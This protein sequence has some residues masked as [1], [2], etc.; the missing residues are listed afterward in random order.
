M[1]EETLFHLAREKPPGERAAFL[2]QACA[3]DAALRRRLEVLL[4]AH[5]D[6]ESLLDR[7]ALERAAEG[8][9]AL[10]QQDLPALGPEPAAEAETLPPGEQPSGILAPG[11][12]VRYFGDYELLEEIA[13]GGMGV[14][15]KARQVSLN[16]VVALKMIL[17]GQLAA[18]ADVQ[19][20]QREAEAAANLDHPHIV[21]IYEVGEHEGQ[22][23]FSMKLI[24]GSSLAQDLARFSK[25]PKAAAQLLAA[26][27]RAVHH[28]HQRGILHRDLK[29]GN[30]L[31]DAAGQPHIT[32]FGLAKR[33]SGEGG[34]TQS[35]AIVGTPSYMAPEQASAE[36]GLTT[37]VDVYSL[38][39]ILYELLTGRP[40]FQGATPL[41][42]VLQ[43]L[44][45]DPVPPSRW[46]T[47]TPADLE[48]ICLK[49]LEKT[50]GKRYAS[51]EELAEELRRFQAGEPVL[52]RP[53][54]S[55]ERTRRWV[56]RRPVAAGLVGVTALL[57][58]ALVGL[59]VGWFS[60]D[61]VQAARQRAES[62][63]DEARR[64]KQEADKQ[65]TVAEA[66]RKEEAKQRAAAEVA[67][68]EEGRLRTEE[69]RLRGVA[70][71][72]Q[73]EADKQRQT[74]EGL[75]YLSRVQAAHHAWQGN[76][77]PAAVA[78]L[79]RCRPDLRGWEYHY[80]HR[81]CFGSKLTLRGHRGGVMRVAFSP[82]G[83][84]IASAS[85]TVK[86]WDAHKGRPVLTFKG[87][88]RGGASSVAFSPDGKRIASCGGVWDEKQ[89]QWGSGEVKVWDAATGREAFTL[90]GHTGYVYC[91]AFSGD[92][93]RI[94]SAGDDFTVRIWD[95]A[96]GQQVLSLKAHT[97]VF[98]VAFSA[99]GK[100][101][102]TGSI[103]RPQGILNTGEERS[104]VKVWDADKGQ[105]LLSL[106]GH[107][108]LVESVAFSADGKRLASASRDGTV[109]VWDAAKGQEILTLKGH[110]SRV[111]SVAFSPDGKRLASGG[112]DDADPGQLKVWDADKGQEVLTFK[113][114]TRGVTSVAFSADGKHIAS[115]S[116]D[117]TV[118]VWEAEKDQEALTLKGHTR[119]VTSVAFSPD[120]KRI[121]SGC[122]G[123]ILTEP[124]Q[125][126]V[127]DA[128]NGQEVLT[129]WWNQGGV[130]SVAFS[131]DGKHIAGGN[132]DGTVKVLDADKGREVLTL[133]A[134]DFVT[135]VAFS[136]D[137]KRI[138]S[139]SGD[140][141]VKVWDVAKGQETHT[142]KGHT[143]R[144]W[145]VAFSPDSK[146]IASGSEDKTVKVWDANKGQE[147]LTLK[148]HTDTVFSVAFS[149][150]GKRIT[151]GSYDKTMKLWDADKGQEVITLKGHLGAVTSV[152]FS[153]DGK[154]IASGSYDKTVKVWNA[155]TG[156]EA[157]TLKG[158]IF[159]VTSVAFSPDGK[160]IASGSHDR[161]VKVWQADKAP[162]P[163]HRQR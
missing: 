85:G 132:W 90:K 26:V 115:A 111:N 145:S 125:L 159:G 40:P 86:V 163:E 1:N 95:A 39:A 64:Q 103:C 139:G 79:D 141:A 2:D 16:R 61:Q 146:R 109:R 66:A 12:K 102:A 73:K 50:V 124:A 46:N 101:I 84:R 11:S 91:V 9:A 80:V 41:D 81:L 161:T 21:P 77:L 155:A 97:F 130:G 93:K 129:L 36:K 98:S 158:H 37:A 151:S 71:A 19:R 42:T 105:E 142:F 65:R 67:R 4:L 22:H 53:V 69:A 34:V 120:G 17:A 43:V 44:S 162:S 56:K 83:K 119:A 94:A 131:P 100:R 70:E 49:C 148:G 126:K 116:W 10:D 149:P 137:G 96:K 33:V 135:S 55:W 123:V 150:D 107:T 45:E 106:K 8:G 35:G 27:A 54:G 18:A 31:I 134:P 153:P 3:G 87:H 20:F 89:Q 25:D 5:D 99:D 51:A 108:D 154:R 74:A 62:A 127:W 112:G 29:P 156:Q 157:L 78:Y 23:Y 68:K 57:L 15:Y 59:A 143:G 7:P 104:P 6:P 128:H 30:I 38:G 82:D 152:A 92:G 121:A 144:V 118:K 140:G 136:P 122:Q 48:T 52:A 32:D 76:N 60:Y 117:G 13:R 113:G 88:T 47:Q 75:E 24:E 14:V 63:R 72:A 147:V 133:K 114:H 28:A 58:L 110:T 138:A 160:R